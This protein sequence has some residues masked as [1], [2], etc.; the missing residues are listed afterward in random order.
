MSIYF[1]V[2]TVEERQ[3]SARAHWKITDLCHHKISTVC[4][5]EKFSKYFEKLDEMAVSCNKAVACI[6][7]VFKYLE[8]S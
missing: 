7:R 3:N 6:Q 2:A 5:F 1:Q 4:H 8:S